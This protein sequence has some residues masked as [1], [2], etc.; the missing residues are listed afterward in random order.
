MDRLD[1]FTPLHKG[2]RAAL[3]DAVRAAARADFRDDGEARTALAAVRETLAFL[4]EQ[5]AHADA[6]IWP[7]VAAAGPELGAS[8]RSDR[9]RIAGVARKCAGAAAR[10]AG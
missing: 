4:G 7:E 9:A 10:R 5:A 8:L 1:L 3:F 6:V 2:L